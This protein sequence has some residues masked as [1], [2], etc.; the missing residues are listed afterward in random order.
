M[1]RHLPWSARPAAVVFA[2]LLPSGAV[3]TDERIVQAARNSYTFKTWL[4]DD[5][6][7]VVSRDG[8][9]TLTGMVQNE[10]HRA[11]AEETLAGL[12]GVTVVN[13]Q[14]SLKQ[15]PGGAN[16]DAT[17]QARVQTA[18]LFHREF[19]GPRI[20]VTVAQGVVTLRGEAETRAQKQRIADYVRGLDGVVQVVDQLTVS[21]EPHPRRREIRKRIDDA[22][23]TA[24]V[25]LAL[26]FNRS[27]SALRTKVRTVNGVVFLTGQA[28]SK[29]EREQVRRVVLSIDGIRSVR[30]Q[31]AIVPG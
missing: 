31:I 8:A 9:V 29:A 1:I 2:V 10:F 20:E 28:A 25:K 30:N 14:L 27:T 15:V 12:P 21:R 13:N 3:E 5:R 17:L 7:H 11:L 19:S 24:Q 18:L 22:S 26:L 6:I 4:K 23:I 16:S